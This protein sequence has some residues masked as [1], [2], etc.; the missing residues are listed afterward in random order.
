MKSELLDVSDN[1]EAISVVDHFL[2]H[3][4]VYVFHNRGETVYLI[5]SADLMTQNLDYLVE[6]LKGNLPW[7]CSDSVTCRS[8]LRSTIAETIVGIANRV[9]LATIP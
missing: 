8:L 4:R 3:S 2:E 1:I 6:A 5:V 7:R 9:S